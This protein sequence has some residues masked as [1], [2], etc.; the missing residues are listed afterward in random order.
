MPEAV[1]ILRPRTRRA[2][3]LALYTE[4]TRQAIYDLVVEEYFTP[5][6][7]RGV[8]WD[9]L[10]DLVQAQPQVHF[11]FGR[12]LVTWWRLDRIETMPERAQR[13]LLLVET[14]LRTGRVLFREI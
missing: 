2:L 13:E 10:Y 1:N 12:W 5:R 4:A 6:K 14:D 8:T 3:D 11:L 7:V 9:P